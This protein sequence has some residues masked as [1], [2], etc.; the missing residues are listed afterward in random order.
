[1]EVIRSYFQH[2]NTTEIMK[3]NN[4]AC[5][6]TCGYLYIKSTEVLGVWKIGKAKNLNKRLAT[7]QTGHAKLIKFDYTAFTWD[8]NIAEIMLKNVIA[9]NIYTI[10]GTK[11]KKELYKAPF[12][13]LQS[14]ITE[15]C[16]EVNVLC[17]YKKLT[18]VMN[19]CD[20]IVD[21]MIYEVQS[22]KHGWYIPGQHIDFTV[23]V[24]KL[25]NIVACNDLDMNNS[26][27]ITTLK[28]VILNKFADKSVIHNDNSVVMKI[29]PC[30]DFVMIFNTNEN[31]YNGFLYTVRM[32]LLN[33][34]E[35]FFGAN[36]QNK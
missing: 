34:T 35:I 18:S 4:I 16:L 29:L 2:E 31:A 8:R 3:Y 7:Y 32:A 12:S 20:R 9:H 26:L 24:N 6:N 15:I 23:L 28:Q 11:G 19:L 5:D 30:D 13:Y 36:K 17:V 1:M 25:M 27:Q 33:V 21:N 22:D 14:I 10:E